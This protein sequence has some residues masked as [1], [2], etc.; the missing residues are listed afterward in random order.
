MTQ[1]FRAFTLIIGSL[2]FTAGSTAN[3][4]T[5]PHKYDRAQVE[6]FVDSLSVDEL[7]CS[8]NASAD[9]SALTEDWL[10]ED[11]FEKDAQA[12][13]EKWLRFRAAAKPSSANRIPA[14]RRLIATVFTRKAAG[15]SCAANKPFKEVV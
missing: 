1:S 10:M 13:W 11:Y 4:A 7:G 15:M 2:L 14:G 3:A 9:F 6:A 8:M 12:I 5:L